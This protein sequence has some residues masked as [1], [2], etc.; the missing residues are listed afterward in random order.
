MTLEGARLL[1]LHSSVSVANGMS[2]D[3]EIALSLAPLMEVE[4]DRMH[5]RQCWSKRTRIASG[6]DLINVVS[7]LDGIES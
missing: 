1:E 5:I 6:L 4:A 3:D 7:Y 2:H